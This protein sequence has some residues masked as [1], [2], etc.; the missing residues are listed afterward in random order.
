MLHALQSPTNELMLGIHNFC[1]YFLQ[2]I[3]GKVNPV[4]IPQLIIHISSIVY[5][6]TFNQ[7]HS[8]TF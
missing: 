2:I 5:Q 6:R 4:C 3:D 8:F 1:F 7:Q